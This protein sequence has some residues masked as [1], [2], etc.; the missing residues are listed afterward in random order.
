MPHKCA[1]CGSIFEDKAPQLIDG[2]VCGAR[3]FLYLRPDYAGTESET[4]KVLR[5]KDVSEEDLDWLDEE[6][7]DRLKNEGKT[8]RLDLE[9]VS[10]LSAGKFHL[11]LQ[12]LMRGEP[13]VIKADEGVYYI[14]L[15]Y[16]MKPKKK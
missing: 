3:V 15:G 7:S 8:I 10:R 4:I 5:Q 16:S 6:F 14:D 13:V 1:R 12:S 11:N 2:C 9:N